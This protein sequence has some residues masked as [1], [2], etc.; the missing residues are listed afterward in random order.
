[1]LPVT[2][3][4]GIIGVGDR[5]CFVLGA[6]IREIQEETGLEIRAI[7][8]RNPARL[9]D[10]ERFLST[11]GDSELTHPI[12]TYTD[13]RH[14]IDDASVDLV[15]VTTHTHMHR[16]P[17]VY[18]LQSGKKVY[19]D[20]PISVEIDDAEAIQAAERQTGNA[21]VMGFTRRYEYSWRTA[22]RLLK[23]GAIGDLHMMQI[24]SVIPYTRYLQMWHRERRFSGGALND[25]SSHHLD[26]FNWMADSSCVRL[27]AFG[28]RSGIF[29]PDPTAPTHCAVCDRDC[30]YRREAG[31]AWSK[32]GA[33]VLEYPSWANAQSVVDR[34]DTCVYAPGSD[35]EDHV[36]ATYEYD[37]GVKAS[38]FWSIFGPPG[39]D[40]ETLELVGSKGRL[41][42]TRS[43]GAIQ[44][45]SDYGK[46]TK[47]I[48]ARGPDFES[49]HYGA[50]L[51]LVRTLRRFCDG[52][53]VPAGSEE[54][55]ESLRMIHATV[56]SVSA[57]G[58]V[59][60]MRRTAGARS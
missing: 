45:I 10:A 39:E 29:K 50:D 14:L 11:A 31:S 16:D 37:N 4:V 41:L 36:I 25:K 9:E 51:E 12:R 34:A 3:G 47:T 44:L 42:L 6:R 2:I 58:A 26:V 28:G 48:D 24:R 30:P 5:G 35:I 8:D 19:L 56:R 38:L 55:I 57:G 60:T 46:T 43:T 18:A 40:Q 53:D 23:G 27:G 7:C 17:T 21:L 49:S 59:Q 15:L 20:K 33:Q 13:Y 32:E 1:M 54:G 22:R 52:G